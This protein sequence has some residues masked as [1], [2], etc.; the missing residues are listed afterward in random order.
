MDDAIDGW[1][2]FEDLVERARLGDV[3]IVEMRTLATNEL[4]TIDSFDG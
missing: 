4:D 2:C 1:M 3:D